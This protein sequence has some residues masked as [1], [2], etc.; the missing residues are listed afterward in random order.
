M[1]N[2]YQNYYMN[3]AYDPYNNPYVQYQQYQ[4]Y[5]YQMYNQYM[6]NYMKHLKNNN[7]NKDEESEEDKKDKVNNKGKNINKVENKNENAKTKKINNSK[8]PDFKDIDENLVYK[9]KLDYNKVKEYAKYLKM[10]KEKAKKEELKNNQENE[11]KNENNKKKHKKPKDKEKEKEKEDKTKLKDD[12]KKKKEKKIKKEKHD[13]NENNNIEIFKKKQPKEPKI[14][15]EDQKKKQRKS[16]SKDKDLNPILK[17]KNLIHNK[18]KRPS[19]KVKTNKLNNKPNPPKNSF[20]SEREKISQ[21][22]KSNAELQF[23]SQQNNEN[24]SE[25]NDNISNENHNEESNEKENEDI[26]VEE[27]SQKQEKEKEQKIHGLNLQSN[28]DNSTVDNILIKSKYFNIDKTSDKDQGSNSTKCKSNKTS[29]IKFGSND[30]Y[31]KLKIIPGH[32]KKEFFANSE[33]NV[34]E[35][36]H[37]FDCDTRSFSGIYASI[38]KEENNII[39]SFSFCADDYNLSFAKFSFFLLQLILHLTVICLFFGDYTINNIYDK[40]NKFDV[41]Y[42]IIPML[43]TFGI[44]L[45][46]NI[47]LRILVKSNNNVLDIKYENC[48]YEHGKTIIR[49]KIFF[50]FFIGF[51]IMIFGFFLVSIFSAVYT[52]SQIKLIACAGYTLAGNFILQ[53]IFCF[54]IA[55]FR[56]CSLTGEKKSR[57]CLYNFTKVLT[58]L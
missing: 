18:N 12:T 22:S 25:I 46:I 34:L 45:I 52:N 20:I 23:S 41:A 49:T 44:C 38:I 26:L 10:Q 16:K 28:G 33:L 35:Y 36:E 48:T 15:L 54:L 58:Y 40:K 57:K 19:N 42:M 2:P 53:I 11:T 24:E 29:G 4:Q 55:A 27:I 1:N 43:L 8:F 21:E 47:P 13:N 50:Y 14:N 3:N 51:I 31:K 9:I 30:F 6:M 17:L 7:Q 39:F 32:K 37:S 5:Q 56:I